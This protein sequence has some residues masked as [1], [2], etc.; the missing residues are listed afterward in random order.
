MS[1]KRYI[2]GGRSKVR[3]VLYMATIVGMRHNPVIKAYYQKLK[4]AD[5]ESKV[6]SVA[7]MRE[8]LTIMNV[9]ER[10]DQIRHD[11]SKGGAT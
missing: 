1:G 6:A 2:C 8:L 9:V 5:K 7:C 10:T 4:C 11:P 3:S